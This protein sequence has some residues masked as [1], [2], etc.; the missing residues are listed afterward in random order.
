MNKEGM[1]MYET[2]SYLSPIGKL[3]LLSDGQNLIGLW[4]ENQKYYGG[5]LSGDWGENDSLPVFETTKKWLDQYFAGKH[6]D[7]SD[8][9]LAPIGTPFRQAVWRILRDIPYGQV[10]TYGEIAKKVA[11]DMGRPS[12]SSQA[13]GGAVGHNPISII[14]PCHRV[15]GTTGSLTGYAGGIENKVK[16]LELEGVEMTGLF[17]PNT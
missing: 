16:L 9:P 17:N 6:P 2:T 4:L 8:L 11:M 10:V 5:N 7:R 13:I 15:V 12:M 1:T 14:I 3:T